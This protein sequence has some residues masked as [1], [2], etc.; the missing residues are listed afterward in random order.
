M[1]KSTSTAAAKSTPKATAQS[2]ANK[3]DKTAASA[4]SVDVDYSAIKDIIDQYVTKQEAIDYTKDGDC[5]QA[6]IEL[7]AAMVR[8]LYQDVRRA[9]IAISTNMSCDSHLGSAMP[10]TKSHV[11]KFAKQRP[12]LALER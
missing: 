7:H 8:E 3:S 4:E 2:K 5:N 1:A 10:A 6:K 12:N 11:G 9:G